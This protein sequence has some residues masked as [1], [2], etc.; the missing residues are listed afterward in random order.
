MGRNYISETG[1]SMAVRL[2]EHCNF[3]KEGLLEQS[4]LA[5]YGYEE[6]SEVSS[7]KDRVFGN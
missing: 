1:R 4:K 7:D 2:R 6:D 3:S 5:Q